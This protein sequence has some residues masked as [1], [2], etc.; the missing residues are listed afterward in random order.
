MLNISEL[1][2]SRV[3]YLI[4]LTENACKFTVFPRRHGLMEFVR[5]PFGLVNAHSAFAQLMRI[6]LHGLE[7]VTFYFDNIC[8]W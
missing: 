7:N 1:D 6:A 5:L 2:M 8:V 3:Y 4:K